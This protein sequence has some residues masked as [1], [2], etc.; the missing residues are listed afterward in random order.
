LVL[1]LF[2]DRNANSFDKGEANVTRIGLKHELIVLLG[3]L[4]TVVFAGGCSL[5]YL[6]ADWES[7]G[8]LKVNNLPKAYDQFHCLCVGDC[9]VLSC[10]PEKAELVGHVLGAYQEYTMKLTKKGA[11]P[12]TDIKP[13]DAVTL[14]E[15][16]FG[17][18]E[19]DAVEFDVHV[20][21]AQ[22]NESKVFILH[23]EPAWAF[24][25]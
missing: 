15:K 12:R 7:P 16:A 14:M 20:N 3:W 1:L 23:Y 6:P 25:S 17:E 5:R 18:R 24:L 19:L 21:L 13:M 4:A 8:R 11:L 9:N 10:E 22:K 2:L